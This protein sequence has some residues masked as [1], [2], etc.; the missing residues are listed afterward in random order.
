MGKEAIGKEQETDHEWH[1][2]TVGHLANSF[3]HLLILFRG[4]ILPIEDGL[5]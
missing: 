5:L 4:S 3:F 1:C 2:I